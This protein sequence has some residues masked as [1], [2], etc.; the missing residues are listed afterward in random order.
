MGYRMK[1]RKNGGFSLLELIVVIA[2]LGVFG[3]I[4]IVTVGDIGG[5]KVKQYTD[6]LNSF[7]RKARTEAMSKE[8]VCGFCIYYENGSCYVETYGEARTPE[9]TLEYRAVDVQELGDDKDIRIVISQPDGSDQQILEDNAGPERVSYIRMKYASGTGAVEEILV[10]GT[11]K[12]E[13]TRITISKGDHQSWI[14]INPV[15]G[16]SEKN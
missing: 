6:I 5:Y 11:S 1:D 15:T 7:M 4:L 3:G 13:N 8:N 2:I 9:D 10:N 12:M 14:D 16:K